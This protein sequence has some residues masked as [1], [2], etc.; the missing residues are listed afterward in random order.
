MPVRIFSKVMLLA[1][2]VS[3]SSEAPHRSLETTSSP[4]GIA[5]SD[6]LP[7]P[8]GTRRLTHR[9]FNQAP[10]LLTPDGWGPLR[11]GMSRAEV[12]AAAGDDARPDAVGGPD[13][14][15]CDEFR[16]REAPVG[17][18]VMIQNGILTRISVSRTSDISTP[19]GIRVG[20]SGA[21]VLTEYGSH[22]VV[23]A[24]QYWEAPA[25]YVTVWRESDGDRRGIRYEI[26]ADDEVA[27]I[28]GGGPSI[29]YVE[30]CV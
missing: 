13:P 12:A 8:P 24:H 27:H 23:E 21:A 5:E 4:Q 3:C 1:L 18:L 30:G 28:R 29:E 6:S 11:I 16:P 22:A 15:T 10:G 14:Q 9:S 25:R 19:A 2:Y 17:V 20:D 7:H 26:N